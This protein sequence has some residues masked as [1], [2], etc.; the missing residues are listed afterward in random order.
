MCTG[1]LWLDEKLSQNPQ[2]ETVACVPYPHAGYSVGSAA[3]SSDGGLACLLHGH[4]FLAWVKEV[5]AIKTDVVK[6]TRRSTSQLHRPRSCLYE[7]KS[8]GHI[9]HHAG[10]EVHSSHGKA[11]S[12]YFLRNDLINHKMLIYHFYS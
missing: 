11:K 3:S 8:H 12:E 6:T 5:M 4:S 2:Q 7:S 10:M 9:Q 1:Q